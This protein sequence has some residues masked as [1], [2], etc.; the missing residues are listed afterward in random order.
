MESI[1]VNL[2]GGRDRPPSSLLTL[3]LETLN[4]LREKEEKGKNNRSRRE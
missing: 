4:L 3:K 2:E 1:V